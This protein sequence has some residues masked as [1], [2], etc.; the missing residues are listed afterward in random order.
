MRGRNAKATPPLTKNILEGQGGHCGAVGWATAWDTST[1]Q[2]TGLSPRY[3]TSIQFSVTVPGK[4][5]ITAQVN[6]FQPPWGRLD[7]KF[8]VPDSNPAQ[9]QL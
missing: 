4:Q 6:E 5:Q 9:I 2:R 7:M 8:L 1:P 3:S